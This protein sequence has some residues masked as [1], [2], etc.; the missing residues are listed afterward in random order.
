M[1]VMLITHARGSGP[2]FKWTCINNCPVLYSHGGFFCFF[3]YSL[4][5]QK[6]FPPVLHVVLPEMA[7]SIDGKIWKYL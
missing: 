3:F 7:E 6:P 4:N 2:I 5:K 1:S